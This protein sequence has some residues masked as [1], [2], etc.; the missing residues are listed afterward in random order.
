ML[1]LF[2]CVFHPAERPCLPSKKVSTFSIHVFATFCKKVSFLNRHKAAGYCS[3]SFEVYSPFMTSQRDSLQHWVFHWIFSFIVMEHEAE[4]I[5]CL[6]LLNVSATYKKHLSPLSH[7]VVGESQLFQCLLRVTT[8]VEQFHYFFPSCSH[9]L[10]V[11]S[12]ANKTNSWHQFSRGKRHV[13]NISSLA[14]RLYTLQRNCSLVIAVI[15][16]RL[17]FVLSRSWEPYNYIFRKGE[18]GL[19]SACCRI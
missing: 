6:P 18:V 13:R 2:L 1:S 14:G 7:I 3:W 16:F 10:L 5:K 12:Q 9:L 11:F 8:W 19:Y 17:L 4:E 15:Q